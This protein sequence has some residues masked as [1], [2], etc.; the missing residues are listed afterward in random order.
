MTAT[1][2]DHQIPASLFLVGVLLLVT[3]LSLLGRAD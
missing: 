2:I 1:L 3:G